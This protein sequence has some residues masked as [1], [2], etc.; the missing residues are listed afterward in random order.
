MPK[1][2]NS[3]EILQVRG[4]FL[5]FFSRL[6]KHIDTGF[7]MSDWQRFDKDRSVVPM[8]P[9]PNYIFNSNAFLKRYDNLDDED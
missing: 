9:D 6:L 3:E 2:L 8:K 4:H 5:D 1:T 7:I